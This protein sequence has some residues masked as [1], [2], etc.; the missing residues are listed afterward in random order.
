MRLHVAGRKPA[1]REGESVADLR[2][3]A[4]VVGMLDEGLR[5]SA[6]ATAG[7]D[8]QHEDAWGHAPVLLQLLRCGKAHAISRC[9]AAVD[10]YSTVKAAYGY[11]VPSMEVRTIGADTP[12]G[13]VV[14]NPSAGFP[15]SVKPP[16]AASAVPSTKFPPD[17]GLHRRLG[18]TS[19]LPVA[20]GAPRSD[21]ARRAARTQ[22]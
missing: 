10:E 7:G 22:P 17:A 15:H 6:M 14:T 2:V 21:R 18:I 20:T 1:R 16:S 13:L 19:S 9:C 4:A 11:A 12:C 8:V 5:G 3:E